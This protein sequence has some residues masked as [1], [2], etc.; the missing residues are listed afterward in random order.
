LAFVFRLLA[1][2]I[3]VPSFVISSS[4]F[5]LSSSFRIRTFRLSSCVF[6]VSRSMVQP[7]ST[8]VIL[9]GLGLRLY[10][11]QS[12]IYGS[13]R[14]RFIRLR[15]YA[16]RVIFL[17]LFILPPRLIASTSFCPRQYHSSFLA[18]LGVPCI[19]CSRWV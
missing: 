6:L 3:P 12:I 4:S 10:S 15:S 9:I 18:L 5:I 7:T 17:L 19:Q 1:L 14:P 2:S 8:I 13:T 11:R 16:S